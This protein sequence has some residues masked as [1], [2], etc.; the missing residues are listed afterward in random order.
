MTLAKT[1]HLVDAIR[2]MWVINQ[3]LMIS[4]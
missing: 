1:R 4:G 2:F 3:E